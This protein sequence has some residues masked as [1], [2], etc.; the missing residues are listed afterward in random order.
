MGWVIL[1]VVVIVIGVVIASRSP[2][3]RGH[4][5]ALEDAMRSETRGADVDR[6]FERPPDEGGLL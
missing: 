3:V 6:Q 1:M 4:G 2:M 5:D